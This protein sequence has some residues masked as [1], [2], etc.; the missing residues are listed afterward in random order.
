M[1]S[2]TP[3]IIV[4]G[5]PRLGEMLAETGA[6]WNVQAT[7]PT[8]TA[9]WDAIEAGSLDPDIAALFLTDG[10]GTTPDEL[11]YAVA[12]FATYCATF[13]FADPVRGR[14]IQARA[15]ELAPH[16]EGGDPEAPVR[17]L[18]IADWHQCVDLIRQ[19][20]PAVAFP[21]AIAAAPPAPAQ[22]E[23]E[24]GYPTGRTSIP[25]PANA[26]PGQMTISCMSSKGGSGKCARWDTIVVDA[27]TG[28]PQT[29][30]NLVLHSD[31]AAVAAFD[32][33]FVSVHPI[34]DKIHS[35]LKETFTVRLRSGRAI[36][37]TANHPML[38]TSG[39]RPLDTLR[40]GETLATP[41]RVP[42]PT[43]P[44]PM[45]PT[46]LDLLA[47]LTAAGEPTTGSDEA[48]LRLAR[49][50]AGHLGR[51]ASRPARTDARPAAAPHA[52]QEAG[53]IATLTRATDTETAHH[54]HAAI[55]DLPR[56]RHAH[57]LDG[58]PAQHRVMPEAAYRL[59][60]A[61]LSRFMSIFWM[62][63]GQAQ[64]T[65]R[66]G[67]SATVASEELA[68]AVQ[69]LLLR[70][71]IQSSLQR[72]DADR[73][74]AW[75]V[76]VSAAS[77][78]AF[79]AHIPLWG[80]QADTLE[81]LIA[82]QPASRA[83]AGCATFTD[84]AYAAIAAVCGR[85]D[86]PPEACAQL[87][88]RADAHA[89][90]RR[91]LLQ[92]LRAWCELA[93]PRA[94]RELGWIYDSEIAWDEI[95]SITPDGVQRVY[96]IEVPG[97]HNFVANDVVIHNST[98]ALCLAGM[99]AKASAA[100]GSPKKVVLVDLDTRDGQVGSLIGQFLPTALNIRVMPTWD[101]KTV[102]AHLVHDQRMGVDTLLAPIRPRNAD[103]VGPEFYRQIIGV[104]QTTHDVVVLDCSVNYL[105]PLLGTA[106]AMSDEILFVTTLATTS[107]QGMARSLTELF[108]DP[109]DGGLGIPR[110][111]VGIVAN[112]VLHNVGMGKDKLLK[113]ALGTP[114]VGQI[115]SDQDAVL[116]AT[117][118][119]KMH[120]LLQH[121]RLGP[122]YFRLA[123][124]CLPGWPLAPITA[125][126]AQQAPTAPPDDDGG[127]KKPGRFR[128]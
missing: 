64:A 103:D 113:A 92:G 40:V 71:G 42:F 79:A 121:P 36:S 74:D 7:A 8:V 93:G 94:E 85:G 106:F 109:A 69:H 107:V 13:V 6:A 58:S 122:A 118:A 57:G 47:A 67:I 33:R 87:G 95:V 44:T 48:V 27:T 31:T 63:A 30:E 37:A 86:L 45:N 123:V 72:A 25:K 51:T 110:E 90:H 77:Y 73:L 56:L 54:E 28:V 75:R 114:L 34:A 16:V 20:L 119:N 104:L 43:K 19:H 1:T 35:G 96:D 32:G 46:E 24:T 78:A 5:D 115:P 102:K 89:G 55:D 15:A 81:R 127:G 38:T 41:A 11:E 21:G 98:T 70:L 9:M 84:E 124:N 3:K 117:N 99:I 49:E 23:P 112:Q 108:A 76:T 66:A 100:A 111:K 116:I 120:T 53:A 52:T 18:P 65:S 2:A 50:A 97:P 12:S 105:D 14:A 26:I 39:W 10:T 91:V 61:Q 128:R 59:P 82:Q 101:Q 88:W 83:S 126:Q 4:V 60:E 17:I 22:P 62:H 68:A 29:I 80:E 125:E